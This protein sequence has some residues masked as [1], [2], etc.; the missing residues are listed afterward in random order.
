MATTEAHLYR[1]FLQGD[2]QESIHLLS[3]SA[4]ASADS[5]TERKNSSEGSSTSTAGCLGLVQ[6]GFAEGIVSL[7]EAAV[8]IS[9]RDNRCARNNCSACHALCMPDQLVYPGL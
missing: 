6:E 1:L 5:V 7:K 2:D 4:S 9:Q 3:T 8:Y